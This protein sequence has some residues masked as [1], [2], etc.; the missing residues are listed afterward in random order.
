[1]SGFH[2][3]R[4][5]RKSA[6]LQHNREVIRNSLWII[7]AVMTVAAYLLIVV[8]INLDSRW[9]PGDRDTGYL[10]NVEDART[11][12]T[13]IGSSMLT[14]FAVV[15]SMTLVALQLAASQYS[16]RIL[17]NYVRAWITKVT[18]GLFLSTFVASLAVASSIDS[19]AGGREEFVPIRSITTLQFLAIICLFAFIA[20]VHGMIKGLR[21]GYIIDHVAH[22]T[23]GVIDD[24]F[25]P[26]AAYVE[27][28]GGVPGEVFGHRDLSG[29]R[30]VVP[31]GPP[32]AAIHHDGRPGVV[33][34]VETDRLVH[35]AR[36]HDTLIVLRR[37][38]GSFL[39]EDDVIAECYG[40]TAP[41]AREIRR[42]VDLGPE[43]TLY[44]DANYGFRLLVDIA[45]KA[46]SPAV[47]DPTTAVQ[48]LDRLTDLLETISQRP[49]PTG[50][51]LDEH[52]VPRLIRPMPTWEQ[53]VDLAFEE[54]RRYGD[55]SPQISRR[56]MAAFDDLLDQVDEPLRPP[57][58]RQR[59]LLIDRVTRAIPDEL[60][61][62]R[63]LTPDRRGLG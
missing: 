36:Q 41:R 17:R 53:F 38:V 54:I 3:L 48:S 21:V 31:V 55:D 19:G 37:R 59:R 33:L 56:L 16:P 1:M 50:V 10:A 9:V 12:V 47:N 11:M 14:I 22:E 62:E 13:L 28:T 25:P 15:F 49:T 35:L 6:R 43:R 24:N 60:D 7:P 18:L 51:Y 2:G 26:A 29:D 32:T 46:L 61:R 23:R 30:S 63:A 40:G 5:E 45:I 27:I 8:A 44:Q 58:E 39:G 42:C 34:G 57:L 4:H 52:E 20:Y